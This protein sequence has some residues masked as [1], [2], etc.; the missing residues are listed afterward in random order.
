MKRQLNSFKVAFKGIWY[1]IKSESHMR[2]H[3][4]AG[5][6]II[7]FSLFFG[8]SKAQWGVVLMLIASILTAEIF[9]TAIEEVCNLSRDS[10]DPIVRIAKDVAAG[11]VLVLAIVAVSVAFIF[12]FDIGK[13]TAVALHVFTTPWLL[14]LFIV[15]IIISI[16][17]IVMGPMGLSKVYHRFKNKK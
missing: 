12:Y 17:F 15:S 13:I 11:A 14:I 5:F 8:L 6:Y 9:N 4:V 7:I 10:F 1:A 3:L 2:F 16:V